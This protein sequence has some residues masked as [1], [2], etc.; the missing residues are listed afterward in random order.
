M[1]AL[2]VVI[3]LC[4]AIIHGCHCKGLF[5]AA[6]AL[7]KARD[8]ADGIV[9]PNVRAF[10]VLEHGAK[11]DGKTDSSINFVRTFEAACNFHG[12]AMV[13][14][15]DGVFLIGPVLFSGP[16]FNP[17]LL[18]FQVNGTVKAQ[19]NMAY[20]RGGDGEDDTDWITFQDI[21]GLILTGHGT[22]YGQ[23]STVWRLNDCSRSNCARL[24]ATL[25]FIKVTDAIIRGIK[26]I[27]P[28]GFHI[29][30]SM[31]R[32]FRIFEVDLHA[33]ENSP[34]TDGIHMSKSDLVKISRTVIATGDDCVSMI[35]GSTNISIKKVIC[36][37][38]HGF[39]IGSLGHYDD[40]ADVSGI[41]VKNCSLRET[42]NG[43]RIKTY[44]TNSPSKASGI[45]FQDLIMTRVRNPIIIDQEYGNKKHSR[46]SKVRIS[47][48]HY[49]NIRGTSISKVAVDLLCSASNPCQGI[50]ID[51][52]NLQY[53]GPQNDNLPFSSNCRNAKVA[54]H[55]FQSPPPC[56]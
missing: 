26:S 53:A 27:D 6:A 34:N 8:A 40:E 43:V 41:V 1:V 46:S 12:D 32:N 36:G 28:K 7:H 2:A 44:K 13:V 20:Y 47:D 19:H 21:D 37:P 3:I 55:G 4:L 16:C 10:N 14:I 45:I 48:V 25:K 17:S 22:F 35:H 30:I 51:N 52:I 11:P 31:S 9:V 5:N 49:I 56:H 18:I 33:P 29:M 50:H 38:G 24:P 15:P 42:D 54:Y 39:S 23:G